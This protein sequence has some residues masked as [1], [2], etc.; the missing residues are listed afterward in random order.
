MDAIAE[1]HHASAA[2]QGLMSRARELM[3][4]R[5]AHPARTVVLL[6]FAHL[7]QPAREAWAREVP[8]GFAP[9]FETTAT[10]SSASWFEPGDHDVTGEIARDLLTASE[11][12]EQAGLSS[13]VD[14]LAPR[15][16]EAA[17]QLATV[18]CAVPPAERH[19]W[20][21]RM[22]SALAPGLDNA[23]L[24]H[25]SALARIAIEWVAASAF[26]TDAL[27]ES[28]TLEGVDLLVAIQGIHTDALGDAL[29][30]RFGDK[31]IVLEMPAPA[32]PGNIALHEAVDPADEAERAAACV[33][34]HVRE[35]RVP[36][37]LV[38]IDR[39]LT[40]RIRA[41]LE[42]GGAAI[43]DETGWKLSTTRAASHVML[44]L[45]SCVHGAGT[46]NVIDWLKNS[47]A[48]APGSVLSIERRVRRE[49][50]REWR[51]VRGTD[52][53]EGSQ[54]ILDGV[55]ALREAMQ[56]TRALAQ[57]LVQLWT[58]LQASGQ[59]RDLESDAAGQQVITALHLSETARAEF[60]QF[61]PAARRM[62]LAEFMAW[63]SDTLE[64][65]K[66]TPPA[67]TPEQ[68]V[69]LPIHQ[70]FGRPFAALVM[71][72]CDEVRL[73]ASPEP[74]GMWTASQRALLGLPTRDMLEEETR[75]AW[76][77]A[78]QT[79][80][81]DILWRCSDAAGEDVLP[82]PLVQALRLGGMGRPGEDARL[83]RAVLA[84][85]T[86]RPAAVGRLLPI[87]ALSASSYDDLRACPYRFFARR[88]L[89]L[90]EPDEIDLDLDKRD[91][92]NWLH[93]VLSAF[94]QQ[95][96][97]G[98]GN[99][100]DRRQLLDET[101]SRVTRD[102]RLD[103]GEFLPFS[104]AWAQARDG[105]LDWLAKHEATERASFESAERDEERTFAG[106]RLFGRI[107]RIDRLPGGDRIVMDYKTENVEK[108]RGRVREPGE[109]TQLA[110]YAALL[111][112][113]A[114]RAAYINIGERGETKT[115]EHK[116][117]AQARDMLLA[118]IAHDLQ[119]ITGGE[120]L[121]ALGEGV[122]CDYCA[123]R[124]LCRKDFWA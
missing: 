27:F 60:A 68:V 30:R 71:P 74:A 22:R 8:D 116:D 56:D 114:L 70:L 11:L 110:F 93:Q 12:I 105:Y 5:H 103:D 83:A 51:H 20:A 49:G 90:Q 7:L 69:I 94:H 106:V 109:D 87:E 17:V 112:E 122:A 57:W 73:P 41:M 32:G 119:R 124:G 98:G 52:L 62:T 81:G 111:D 29:M 102:M 39:V 78:L 16:A 77:H 34:R 9:R 13:H 19:A 120:A 82:S 107:D 66:F 80:H 38:A 15:L 37:A 42:H 26:R 44:A 99:T 72:G 48:W 47:P 58:L 61:A 1:T 23:V 55:N 100:S 91:F 113:G 75:Q 115:V 45:R 53:T 67:V 65:G 43:R 84:T 33:L 79:P 96:A 88:Q 18:A 50:I 31:A 35:G 59:W 6:P 95:L 63:A 85:G 25:E 54:A 104:A 76:A 117:I 2:I 89:G 101:A 64:A 24:L 46:D 86:A 36:V 14:L 123:A 108:T 10:W 97:Q 4:A 3:A 121:A 40:R 21:A 118:G 28:E 92:G